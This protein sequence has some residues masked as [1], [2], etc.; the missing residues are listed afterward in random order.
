MDATIKNDSKYWDIIV[1]KI[2]VEA[3]GKSI[4]DS[5][6]V[7]SERHGIKTGI[8]PVRDYAEGL[9]VIEQLRAIWQARLHR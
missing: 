2:Y 5:F 6:M 3:Q 9:K 8:M 4:P 1:S 7:I